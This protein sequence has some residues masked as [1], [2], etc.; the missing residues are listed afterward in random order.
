[1]VGRGHSPT[2]V[3]NGSP[4]LG[5]SQPGDAFL[6]IAVQAGLPWRVSQPKCLQ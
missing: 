3:P 4:G 2:A 5:A 6:T 1:M